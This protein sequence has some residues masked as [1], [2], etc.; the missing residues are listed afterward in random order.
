MNDQKHEIV[1]AEATPLASAM[2][3]V[4]LVAYAS[5]KVEQL[6]KLVAIIVKRTSSQDWTD[7][8]G[9][10]WLGDSGAERIMPLFGICVEH[11]TNDKGNALHR[12]DLK[13]EKGSYFVYRIF[14]RASIQGSLPWVDVSGSCSSRKSFFARAHGKDRPQ[15]DIDVTD[16]Q[17]D[18]ISDLYRNAV[19]RLLG[20][21][22][23]TWE[24]LE[25]AG[26]ER[27]KGGKVT[28][29]G[30]KKTE[31]KKPNSPPAEAKTDD[32]S[33]TPATPS[34]SFT[35]EPKP[36]VFER[37]TGLESPEDA[38]QGGIPFDGP[39]VPESAI[40]T[41]DA[42]SEPQARRMFAIAMGAG[43]SKEDYQAWFDEMGIGSD[44]NVNRD[45]YEKICTFFAKPK[46]E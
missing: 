14:G 6:N 25:A 10:P 42:I 39:G 41:A 44:K 7:L 16:I 43:W 32:A 3:D 9:K 5:R 27:G 45:E 1:K 34:H 35:T 13:D 11:H 2:D 46:E 26:I 31:A 28:Y 8:D 23:L 19:V 22:N 12:E 21:R 37:P 38:P 20:I 17:N 40:S 36:V 30:S 15:S 29:K 33:P 18:A 24:E 4:D